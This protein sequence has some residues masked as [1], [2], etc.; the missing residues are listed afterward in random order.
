MEQD[1]TGLKYYIQPVSFETFLRLE[2][3]ERRD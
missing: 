3:E 1:L 2:S